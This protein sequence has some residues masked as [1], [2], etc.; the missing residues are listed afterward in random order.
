MTA[1]E[2]KLMENIFGKDWKTSPI[3]KKTGIALIAQER[4]EQIEKHGRTHTHDIVEN[5]MHELS[6]AASA[7]CLISPQLTD[8]PEKWD[9]NWCLKMIQKPYK[10]RLIIAGALI[11][12]ELDRVIYNESDTIEVDEQFGKEIN[13]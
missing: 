3:P 6:C 7:L 5:N 10:E 1:N 8:M 13:K 12:A 4:S 9:A 2:Q 11:A